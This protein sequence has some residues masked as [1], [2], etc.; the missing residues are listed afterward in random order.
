MVCMSLTALL[1]PNCFFSLFILYNMTS[2]RLTDMLSNTLTHRLTD[3][4]T[5]QLLVG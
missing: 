5:I 3:S 2:C 1:Q 4:L